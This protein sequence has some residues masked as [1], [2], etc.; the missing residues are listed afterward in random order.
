MGNISR[1][2]K[3]SKNQR[4]MLQIKNTVTKKKNAFDGMP[5]LA[6]LFNTVLEVLPMEIRE[7]KTIK[8]IQIGNKK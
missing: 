4:E 2:G 1:R 5:T 8:E 6:L 7:E 3:N